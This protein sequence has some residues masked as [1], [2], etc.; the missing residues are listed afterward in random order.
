MTLLAGA[1]APAPAPVAHPVH[2]PADASQAQP[3]SYGPQYAAAHVYLEPG[4]MPA[5]VR[6]WEATFGGSHYDFVDDVNVTPTPSK[7]LSTFITSPVGHLSVFDYHTPKPHPF[8]EERTGWGVTDVDKA[9]KAAQRSGA[10][11]LVAPFD[12][13]VGR[14][15]VI[16]FPGGLNTQ[17][18]LNFTS[19]TLPELTTTP[20]NRVYITAGTL[21]PFLSSYLQFTHGRI[22]KDEKRADAAEV[23]EPNQ[24]MH[25]ISITS[26]FGKTVVFVTDGHLPHPYGEESIGYEVA[27]LD[28]AIAKAKA[29]GADVLAK[30]HTANGRTSA[31]VRFPGG[32][33]AEVHQ[34]VS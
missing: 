10:Y 33:V 11:E 15:A 28:N 27:D 24:V 1:A 7:A 9:V 3:V 23:G 31:V 30:P 22:V 6:S 5:F 13:P 19:P 32:Y 18:W 34:N 26:Q 17:L 29:T 4:T 8:G 12:D 2:K 25:R 16:Q 14:D 20:E 21:R